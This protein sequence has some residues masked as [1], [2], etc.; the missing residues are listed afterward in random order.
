[1]HSKIGYN[2]SV[3]I[4]ME[5][6]KNYSEINIKKIKKWCDEPNRSFDK[7]RESIRFH[8]S[9]IVI[10]KR[11]KKE[12]KQWTSD[13]TEIRKLLMTNILYDFKDWRNRK[14]CN[15]YF[16]AKIF[17]EMKIPIYYEDNVINFIMDKKVIFAGIQKK[18]GDCELAYRCSNMIYQKPILLSSNPEKVK[19]NNEQIDVKK[20]IQS[21]LNEDCI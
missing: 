2:S 17:N 11:N 3:E 7:L 15:G 21:I 4:L 20:Y 14:E 16:I 19:I 6:E 9:E 12:L 1:M 13:Y 10:K 5:L 18:D 8:L